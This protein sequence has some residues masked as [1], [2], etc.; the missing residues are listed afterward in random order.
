MR[1]FDDLVREAASGDVT[2]WDFGWLDGRATEERPP[3]GYA[4]LLAER[5]ARVRSA[6]DFD[7]G[8]ARW[9]RRHRPCQR[10]CA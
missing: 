3:W 4:R 2:G 7:T 1:S 8:G 10:R 6:L 5:L 9:S